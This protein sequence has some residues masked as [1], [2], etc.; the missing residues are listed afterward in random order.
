MG[1][2]KKTRYVNRKM[3]EF[4]AL[5]ELGDQERFLQANIDALAAQSGTSRSEVMTIGVEAMEQVDDADGARPVVVMERIT[6][7]LISGRLTFSDGKTS[8]VSGAI[9]PQEFT[10]VVHRV[11]DWTRPR[12]ME[13]FYDEVDQRDS[14]Q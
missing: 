12:F 10:Q 6:E 5:S 13:R 4:A 2:F 3:S 7:A 11:L 9:T 8:L 1:F 14:E